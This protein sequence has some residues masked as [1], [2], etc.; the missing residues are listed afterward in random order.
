MGRIHRR[1]VW[2]LP[3]GRVFFYVTRR[4]LHKLHMNICEAQ[5]LKNVFMTIQLE[6]QAN[7]TLT[8]WLQ[9]IFI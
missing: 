1:L 5:F 7:Q 9:K 6:K 2:A 3:S 4:I 8:F